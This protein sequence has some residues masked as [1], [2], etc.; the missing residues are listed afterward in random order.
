MNQQTLGSICAFEG[1]GLHTG[2]Y[3]RMSIGPA[4]ADTGIRFV[5]TDIGPDASVDA[6][7][8]NVSDTVRST[9]LT[10]GEVTVVTVEHVLSA[11]T[12]MGIDNAE[13]RLDNAEVPILDG[14]ALPYAE[15]FA[16][17]GIE[18]Q[19]AP[20]RMLE[21]SREVEVR[22]GK[23][24]AWVRA[25]PSCT[26]SIEITVDFNSEVLDVQSARW[27]PDTDFAS[28]IAPCRT[29]VFFHE[30]EALAARGLIKG[31]AIDNAIVVFERPV[32]QERIDSLC[33]KL[34]LPSMKV[35][36]K[37]FLSNTGLHFPNECCRHKLLDLIGDL[38]LAGGWLNARVSAFKPGH[39]IN[40][41]AAAKIREA[42]ILK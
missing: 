14:S 38:R 15:A 21:L 41:M 25:V 17:A 39:A 30:I 1:K 31:G 28:E 16:K 13:I 33:S 42:L 34:G 35:D 11:F 40:T 2:L 19:D 12:G 22:D 29:F 3:A 4:P 5:R 18:Q 26:P 27:T 6:L 20:R 36:G 24:G 32:P 10:S 23:S 8:E 7:A 9:S 37:G